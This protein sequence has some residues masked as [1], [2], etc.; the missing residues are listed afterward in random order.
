MHEYD[1]VISYI[2]LFF[3]FKKYFS[4]PGLPDNLRSS[5]KGT[6]Y[7]SLICPRDIVSLN[8]YSLFLIFTYIIPY[9][10]SQFVSIS[11]NGMSNIFSCSLG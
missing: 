1:L 4:L 8:A 5:G 7:I 6:F 3:K 2:L 10:I 9:L 11:F